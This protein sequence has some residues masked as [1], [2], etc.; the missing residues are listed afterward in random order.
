MD[1]LF[2]LTQLVISIIMLLGTIMWGIAHTIM[3]NI[4][5]FGFLALFFFLYLVWRLV[6]LSWVEYKQE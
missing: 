2:S 6:L 5:S 3:G 1:K 4:K